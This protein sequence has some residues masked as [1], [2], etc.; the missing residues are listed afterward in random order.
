MVFGPVVIGGRAPGVPAGGK[1]TH[2]RLAGAPAAFGGGSMGQRCII[3]RAD[4]RWSGLFARVVRRSRA[5]VVPGYRYGVGALIPSPVLA[6][7]AAGWLVIG[8]GYGN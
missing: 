7:L 1:V 3:C 8:F 5:A 2:R 4:N 6:K